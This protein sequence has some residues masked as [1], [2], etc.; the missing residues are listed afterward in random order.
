[1]LVNRIC[2]PVLMF[3]RTDLVTINK[4][5]TCLDNKP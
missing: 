1:M 3:T 2:V 4:I 5:Q